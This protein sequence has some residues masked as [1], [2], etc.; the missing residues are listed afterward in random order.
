[1]YNTR[2]IKFHYF[3]RDEMVISLTILTSNFKMV[4]HRHFSLVEIGEYALKKCV[5]QSKA[6][7]DKSA[8][9]TKMATIAIL[10][11]LKYN[12]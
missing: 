2:Y 4:A 11:N 12:N 6:F 8:L 1:M 10:K 7:F 5:E 3:G 9:P